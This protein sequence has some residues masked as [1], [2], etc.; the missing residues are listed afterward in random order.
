[1]AVQTT[2]A[3]GVRIEE[4]GNGLRQPTWPVPMDPTF[5]DT[6]APP[7]AAPRKVL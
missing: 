2:T 6:V 4:D 1:M 3:L 7:R 5:T